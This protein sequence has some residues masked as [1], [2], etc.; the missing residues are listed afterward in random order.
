M[1]TTPDRA[2]VAQLLVSSSATVRLVHLEAVPVIGSTVG[3]ALENAQ[4]R[5]PLPQTSSGKVGCGKPSWLQQR[6]TGKF[7]L[8]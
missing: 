8:H 4:A 2:P 1:K 3:A 7:T 5:G 6:S